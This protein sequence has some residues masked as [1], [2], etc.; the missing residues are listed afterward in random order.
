MAI[1]IKMAK[2][3]GNCDCPECGPDPCTAGCAC[4]FEYFD[5]PTASFSTSIDVTGYFITAHDL[6]ISISPD[7][8][9]SGRLQVT[10]GA[11][12]WDSGCVSSTGGV[13]VSTVITVPAGVT[14]IG[15]TFTYGCGTPAGP[16]PVTIEMYCDGSPS[17]P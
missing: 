14:S 2:K 3:G 7:D 12:S 17:F 8:P 6:F 9:S 10:A 16:N 11:A 4:D 15:L 13:A 5:T 1:W